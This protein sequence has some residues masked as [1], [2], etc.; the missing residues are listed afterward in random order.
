MKLIFAHRIFFYKTIGGGVVTS[1]KSVCITFI[2]K[3]SKKD[4]KNPLNNQNFIILN[5]V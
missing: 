2:K 3:R 4:T 5:H 1:M